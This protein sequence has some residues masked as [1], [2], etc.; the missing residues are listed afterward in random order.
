[1][2]INKETYDHIEFY[3]ETGRLVLVISDENYVQLKNTRLVFSKS[4]LIS[5]END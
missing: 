1:M 3:D 4:E 5:M 2:Q